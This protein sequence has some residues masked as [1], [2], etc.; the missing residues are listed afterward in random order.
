M[1]YGKNIEQLTVPLILYLFSNLGGFAPADLPPRIFFLFATHQ[2]PHIIQG[3][4]LH[5]LTW[6]PL[7]AGGIPHQYSPLTPSGPWPR[8]WLGSPVY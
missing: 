3:S 7:L 1:H 2:N 4:T 8:H 6:F 5:T